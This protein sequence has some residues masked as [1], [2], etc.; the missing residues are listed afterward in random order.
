M[1]QAHLAAVAAR[2]Q[3]ARFERIMGAASVTT[4]F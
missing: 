3:V 1:G 4:A 2:N